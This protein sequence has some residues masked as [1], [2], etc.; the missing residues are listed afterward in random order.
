MIPTP[1]PAG[2]ELFNVK[3]ALCLLAMAAFG[4]QPPKSSCEFDGF[5]TNA[6]LAEVR[7]QPLAITNP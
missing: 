4:Q 3:T 6:K 2:T 7:P 5:D 1:M